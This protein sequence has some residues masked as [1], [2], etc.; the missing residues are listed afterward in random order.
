MINLSQ[1]QDFHSKNISMLQRENE[2]AH[3]KTY[4]EIQ[5]I[6][7]QIQDLT[8]DIQEKQCE[9]VGFVISL[10]K[11]ILISLFII[12]QLAF[13]KQELAPYIAANSGYR[14]QKKEFCYTGTRQEPLIEIEKWLLSAEAPHFLWLTGEPGAG[15]ST[16]A[17]TVC[18]KH[19]KSKL[20]WAQFFINRNEQSTT[21]PKFFFPSIALQLA[22]KSS[23]I[24]YAIYL[25]LRENSSLID[26]VNDTLAQ[27]LFV[28]PLKCVVDAPTIL[29]VVDA[30]DE[31]K[32]V[33]LL[34]KV[35]SKMTTQLQGNTKFLFSS[36]A[37]EVIGTFW[38]AAEDT[39]HL[40][41]GTDTDS[42]TGDVNFFIQQKL[43][44]IAEDYKLGEWPGE[45]CV[46]E[47]CHQ[48]SGLFIWATTAVAHI[49]TQV[50]TLGPAY[51][52][53]QLNGKDM[54]KISKLYGLILDNM[55]PE[56]AIY[57]AF[58]TFRQIV[59]AI[60]VLNTPFSFGVLAKIL[61]LQAPLGSPA[62]YILH[63]GRQ[64][65]TVL[66][67][68]T[69]EITLET[70]PRLHKSFFEYV[71]SEDIKPELRVSLLVS[72][73]E[74]ASKCY[75]YYQKHGKAGDVY[76]Q[77]ARSSCL[78]LV[79]NLPDNEKIGDPDSQVARPSCQGLVNNLP[80]DDPD[81]S[82]C[83]LHF[84]ELEYSRYQASIGNLEY[85]D[86]QPQFSYL[87]YST[88]RNQKMDSL[89]TCISMFTHG[90]TRTSYDNPEKPRYLI[91]LSALQYLKYQQLGELEDL[92]CALQ[93][94]GAAASM[95]SESHSCDLLAEIL[96]IGTCLICEAAVN[97]AGLEACSD[98]FDLLLGL[99][100]YL[101][102]S[103][104]ARRR[105]DIRQVTSAVIKGCLSHA[106]LQ[107]A[108]EVLEHGLTSTF[109]SSK[110]LDNLPQGFVDDFGQYS[111]K[112]GRFHDTEW[113]AAKR[114]QLVTEIGRTPGFENLFC[115]KQ[116]SSLC[117]ASQNGPIVILTS[118]NA[119]CDA[120]IL[121]HPASNPLHIP[122]PSVTLNMLEHLRAVFELA[123]HQDNV[124][125]F[126]KREPNF[127]SSSEHLEHVLTWL[128]T[129]VVSH[130]YKALE[131]VGKKIMR[132][133]F[134]WA[135]EYLVFRMAF[136]MVGYGG[137]QLVP[138]LDYPYMP[139][140]PLINLS[141]HIPQT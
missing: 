23:E 96:W 94:M 109:G 58:N 43:Q 70:I 119:C 138:L 49:E 20:L 126:G 77:A 108:V 98:A 11:N 106:N 83:L 90:T 102:A 133:S 101:D 134:I 46:Q 60:V 104:E 124:R 99:G 66:V 15:K 113:L 51:D 139:Q 4:E 14:E 24:A 59:G 84:G 5:K 16:L 6:L 1:G 74:V 86:Y 121:L 34:T 115:P 82:A 64:L 57:W 100:N 52:L 117:Q 93:N 30:L 33:K 62:D 127:I 38:N 88:Y 118:H 35:L 91:Q 8:G 111:F 97:W 131:L 45:N 116:Y 92:E 87:A 44:E 12:Q 56:K 72:H 120:I 129:H 68:G 36:R 13:I 42:S 71:T 55:Y 31:A 107:R 137:C 28:E 128:W 112:Q 17:A 25:A 2:Q 41:I 61:D 39:K 125:L 54:S 78:W 63:F 105:I 136:Q 21:D 26:E 47:L 48:A 76:F 3:Q 81:I 53:A 79:K 95:A 89:N 132:H 122:L 141:N 50:I 27:Q 40:S 7:E 22:T 123:L 73:K 19:T 10:H 75:N 29:V 32:N 37:E 110:Q 114:D 140:L 135:N 69:D 130:I 80:D 85:S 18:T 67:V 103:Q 9:Q 65:R